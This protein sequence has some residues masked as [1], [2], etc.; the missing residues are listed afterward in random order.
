MATG[1]NGLFGRPAATGKAPARGAKLP[2][3]IGHRAITFVLEC[4]Q[5]APNCSSGVQRKC[6]NGHR[7]TARPGLSA[8]DCLTQG[9]MRWQRG[10]PEQPRT[11]IWLG[12]LVRRSAARKGRSELHR[13]R[14]N[15][16]SPIMTHWRKVVVR[17]PT[18]PLSR[19][20]ESCR[21]SLLRQC[22]MRLSVGPDRSL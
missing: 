12:L 13:P 9:S 10:S 22:Q 4:V 19:L 15:V 18:A 3:V 14:R 21:K 7:K 16:P 20:P 5:Q 2:K 11:E 1:E 6:T 8:G 17:Q